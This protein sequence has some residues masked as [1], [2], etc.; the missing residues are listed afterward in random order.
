LRAGDACPTVS[1]GFVTSTFN[2][3]AEDWIA[4]LS[5]TAEAAIFTFNWTLERIAA[6]RLPEA[7]KGAPMFI[8]Q[9]PVWAAFTVHAPDSTA[10]IVHEPD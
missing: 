1:A 8:V 3:T 5:V 6:L 10:F 7:S 2:V 9:V 4:T